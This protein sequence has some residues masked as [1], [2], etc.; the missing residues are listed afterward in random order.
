SERKETNSNSFYLL[1]WPSGCSSTFSNRAFP[2]AVSRPF[3]GPASQ[4][5][6][7]MVAGL[8]PMSTKLRPYL[9]YDTTVSICSTCFRKVEGKIVFE[10]G[11]VYLLKRCPRHG[12]E[13]VLMSDDIDYY[14]R[15]R[16][17]F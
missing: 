17:V 7:T 13:R 9:F 1:T 16:E 2:S 5:C 12:F 15:T 11:C 14:R 6:S 3:S 8:S 10:E 4:G